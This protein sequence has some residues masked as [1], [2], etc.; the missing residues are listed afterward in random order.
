MLSRAQN[1]FHHNPR[2]RGP[3][4]SFLVN[5]AIGCSNF[6]LQVHRSHDEEDNASC[7]L[8]LWSNQ[9]FLANAFP[10]K[11]LNIATSNFAGA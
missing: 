9:I 11:Q 2:L 5:A 7:D 3:V 6:K 8:D 10:P 1:T 4:S